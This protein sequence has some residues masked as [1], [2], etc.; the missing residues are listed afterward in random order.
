MRI[1]RDTAI[2]I[3]SLFTGFL[4]WRSGLLTDLLFATS[5]IPLLNSFVAGALFTSV[6][7]VGPATAAIA[8]LST[9]TPLSELIIVGASGALLVEIVMFAA[10]KDTITRELRNAARHSKSAVAH[11]LVFRSKWRLMSVLLGAL[12]IASPLP[13]EPGIFLLSLGRPSWQ[14]ALIATYALNA[15]GIGIVAHI[16]QRIT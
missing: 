13:D 8:H 1:L 6:I 10:M 9:T 2:L 12:I 3:L 14:T 16:A 4:L 7:T 15:A 5:G 11:H